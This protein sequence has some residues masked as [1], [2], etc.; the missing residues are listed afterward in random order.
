MGKEADTT[1]VDTHVLYGQCRLLDH[2]ALVLCR[3]DLTTNTNERVLLKGVTTY[4][5]LLAMPS[6]ISTV[7]A[8]YIDRL[9]PRVL[10]SRGISELY[11]SKSVN[12]FTAIRFWREPKNSNKTQELPPWQASAASSGADST[13]IADPTQTERGRV[14]W[15]G[16]H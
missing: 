11:F 16:D 10:D 7:D 4:G 5:M 12:S 14:V 15:G 13:I 9:S 6:S 1:A 2:L 3:E 8:E